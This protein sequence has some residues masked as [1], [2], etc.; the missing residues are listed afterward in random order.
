MVNLTDRFNN[1]ELEWK[2]NSVGMSGAKPWA[3][4]LC[5]VSARAIQ[6]RL[7]A[8][9]GVTGW[10][11][12]YRFE[13]KGTVCNLSVWDKDRKEWVAKENGSQETEFEAFKGGISSAFKRVAASGFGIGRYLYSLDT[14]FATCSIEKV[15]GW[16]RAKTKDGTVFY[17]ETPMLGEPAKKDKPGAEKA[18]PEQITIIREYIDAGTINPFDIKNKY[19]RNS[20]EDLLKSE[21]IEII[22]KAQGV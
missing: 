22:N 2:P 15:K 19:S 1:D 21:A 7:D 9:Y 6:D 14:V 20:A 3:M 18:T 4:V 16:N 17:W 13:S 8:V 10:K 5:Y 11:D 12:T